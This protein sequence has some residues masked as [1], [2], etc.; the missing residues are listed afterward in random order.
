MTTTASQRADLLVG[1]RMAG[2]DKAD[3]TALHRIALTLH[4]WHELE[5]GDEYGWIIEREGEDGGEDEDGRPYMRNGNTGVTY[6]PIA[7]REAGALR[8]LAAIM[9]RY[10]GLF[11]S[12]VQGDPRGASLYLV[13]C[14]DV[15]KGE[16]VADYYQ[17]GI[18]IY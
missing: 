9:K 1:L 17:R 5:C 13:R 18:A 12:Y 16:D 10:S 3:A 8:R 2:I 14:E 4:R 11:Y 6:G 7:D 15:P